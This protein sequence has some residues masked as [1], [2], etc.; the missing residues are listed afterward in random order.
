MAIKNS[1]PRNFSSDG[2]LQMNTEEF[3]KWLK[4]FDTDKDGRIS[5]EELREAVREM[6]GWFTKWKCK[7]GF[8][9]A[10]KDGDGFIEENEINNLKD[11]A[12]KHLGIRVITY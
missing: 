7:G 3:K 12:L 11:F 4:K 6:G 8:K 10:D 9:S 2:K 1:Y 5:Q